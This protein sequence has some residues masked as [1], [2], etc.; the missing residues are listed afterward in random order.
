M[1][2]ETFA[3]MTIGDAKAAYKAAKAAKAKVTGRI[4][5]TFADRME[6]LNIRSAYGTNI[7]KMLPVF[8]QFTAAY[9][10]TLARPIVDFERNAVV[11]TNGWA[12]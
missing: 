1:E 3:T 8:S 4:N 2:K 5:L 7:K 6:G 9:K 12:T 11:A 10:D